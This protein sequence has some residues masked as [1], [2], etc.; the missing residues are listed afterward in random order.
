MIQVLWY[1]LW[2]STNLRYIYEHTKPPNFTSICRELIENITFMW[3]SERI[4]K[5]TE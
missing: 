3:S 2:P 5:L 1:M 4:G